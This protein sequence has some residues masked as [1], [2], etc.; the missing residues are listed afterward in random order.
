MPKL[1]LGSWLPD[2]DPL[3]N[4]GLLMARNCRPG[5]GHYL[6][7]ESPIQVG[8]GGFEGAAEGLWVCTQPSGDIAQFLGIGGEIYRIPGRTTGAIN[9]SGGPDYGY[10]PGRWRGVTYGNLDIRTNGADPLQ[11]VDLGLL[12]TTRYTDLAPDA[13]RARYIAVVRDFVM[14]AYTV[15]DV[16]G[17]VSHRVRWH[18]IDPVTGLPDPT[19]WDISLSTRADFQDIPDIGAIQGLTGGQFGTI[20]CDHGI[21]RADFGGQYVFSFTTLDRTVG[22]IAPGSIADLAQLTFFLGEGGGLYRFDGNS[23]VQINKGKNDAFLARDIELGL[24]DKM[25]AIVDPGRGLYLLLYA[26]SGAQGDKPNRLLLYDIGRDQFTIND[27]TGDLLGQALSFARDLDDPADFLD[28]DSLD[29]NLDDPKL[30]VGGQ[31]R[32][33]LLDGGAIKA[34]AGPALEAVFE[35]GDLELVEG[36]RAVMNRALVHYDGGQALLRVGTRER[37]PASMA[38]G[39]A[40]GPQSDGFYRFRDVGR[41]HRARLEM[42]GDWQRAQAIEVWGAGLGQ[43]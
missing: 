30:W 33:G 25:S 14:V 20:L 29:I 32:P 40:Y 4:P 31:V 26:G 36:R 35:T 15:D 18:G 28:L 23:A 41:Y 13:P 10:N 19:E 8:L 12:A 42:S 17:T 37:T 43:R 3:G 6:P 24:L 16:D 1:A 2:T 34:L 27:V 5:P 39:N 21:S 11:A 9:V 38:F 7:L 22:C